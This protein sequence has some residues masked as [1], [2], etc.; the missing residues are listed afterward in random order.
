MIRNPF[1]FLFKLFKLFRHRNAFINIFVYLKL[2]LNSF[3]FFM[4]LNYQWHYF[5]CDLF[6]WRNQSEHKIRNGSIFFIKGN[7][8]GVN[9]HKGT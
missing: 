9:K 3:T 6:I 1:F 7:Y 4:F 8:R 2:F 5:M